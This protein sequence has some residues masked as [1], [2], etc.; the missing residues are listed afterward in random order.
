MAH[1]ARM[2]S[3][4]ASRCISGGQSHGFAC[5]ERAQSTALRVTQTTSVF[6]DSAVICVKPCFQPSSSVGDSGVLRPINRLTKLVPELRSPNTWRRVMPG[7]GC[8]PASQCC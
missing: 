7:T 4:K 3:E 8:G 5:R 1:S 2:K 6:G